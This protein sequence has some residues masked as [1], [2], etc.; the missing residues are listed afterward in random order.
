MASAVATIAAPAE[1][2][3]AAWEHA[4]AATVKNAPKTLTVDGIVKFTMGRLPLVVI[5]WSLPVPRGALRRWDMPFLSLIGLPRLSALRRLS[6]PD[7]R[8][9]RPAFL[10]DVVESY[11]ATLRHLDLGKRSYS[12]EMRCGANQ[13]VWK[14]GRRGQR[15]KIWKN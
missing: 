12:A 4:I 11:G 1:E 14:C 8:L 13:S 7:N 15:E 10:A 3:A 6:L 9:S 5:P 2:D